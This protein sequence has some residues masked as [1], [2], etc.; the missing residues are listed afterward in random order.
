MRASADFLVASSALLTA[1][2]ERYSEYHS[3]IWH[4]SSGVLA[5]RGVS[6]VPSVA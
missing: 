2:R 5:I 4:D 3:S 6:G 1:G